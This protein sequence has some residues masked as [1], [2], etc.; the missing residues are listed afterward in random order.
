MQAEP[1]SWSPGAHPLTAEDPPSIGAYR[2][3]GRLGEGGMGAV[4]LGLS[5]SGQK[6]AVKVIRRELAGTASFRARFGSEVDHAQRVASFCTARVLEHGELNGRPYLV[7]EH[8]DGPSLAD[9]VEANGAL[10]AGPLRSL[11]VGVATAL[12]A[13]HAVRLVHRDLKPGNVLLSPTGPRVIDF[14]IARALD[15]DE[16]HT[17]TGGFVG[18]PG[19]VA[20][21]QLFDGQVSTAVDV[22]AWG[23]LIAYAATGRHPYGTGN[24]ATLA[25]RAQQ[26]QHDL[27]G[28]PA[29]LL[30]LVRAALAPTSAGRP[31]A[32]ALLTGLVG[33]S[34]D[35]QHAAT[36]IISREWTP[37]QFSPM[38][39]HFAP[40][41][42]A[43]REDRL[44][45]PAA[46][47]RP[48]GRTWVL[49][50][51]AAVSTAVL[52]GGVSVAVLSLRNDKNSGSPPPARQVSASAST[53]PPAAFTRVS[54]PCGTVSKVTASELAP[55]A[56]PT[57]SENVADGVFGSSGVG[58]GCTWT[59]S[60]QP[61]S[62]VQKA[63]SLT[64]ELV[65]S[66][67]TTGGA[68]RTGQDFATG[69]S[70][71]QGRANT[72]MDEV[73]Y[74][75]IT[76]LLGVGDE[77]FSA[78]SQGKQGKFTIG[79]AAVGVRLKNVLIEVRYGGGDHPSDPKKKAAANL[80]ALP[81]QQ[82]REAAERV[83]RELVKNLID[84]PHCYNE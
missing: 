41:Q 76:P 40:A 34:T 1:A 53:Q 47:S 55:N 38:P 27:T 19:W 67:E 21:E 43:T 36:D 13:I 28:V 50:A 65:I 60:K 70:K 14:G 73:E 39:N 80:T 24:L 25:A 10:S 42:T 11:A 71:L 23:T 48:H 77:A 82:V 81:Q 31:R 72:T 7:T 8:I 63:R 5:D 44:T 54:D 6:V 79:S 29:E 84:C 74:G 56:T 22:F 52:V 2:L 17:Q 15:S 26:G 30:P 12:T 18:S 61:G 51:I 83:A 75:P 66:P 69:R 64:V 49:T 62:E 9:Y 68:N 58:S 46:P 20:P 35:P 16:R 45:L 33:T 57:P 59:S 37:G 32:D 3:L 4:Y 78:T